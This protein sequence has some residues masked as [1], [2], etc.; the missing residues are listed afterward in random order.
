MGWTCGVKWSRGEKHQHDH[1]AAAD[2]GE[3]N[4]FTFETRARTLRDSSRSGQTPEEQDAGNPKIPAAPED[5]SSGSGEKPE[6]SS[7][8]AAPMVTKKRRFFPSAKFPFSL[9]KIPAAVAAN[10]TGSGE[11][12]LDVDCAELVGK[13]EE[14]ERCC[15]LSS[16]TVAEP[17]AR[18]IEA[19]RSFGTIEEVNSKAKREAQFEVILAATSLTMVASREKTGQ[20]VAKVAKKL[21]SEAAALVA[22]AG[23]IEPQNGRSN[24]FLFCITISG[25]LA[26]LPY[27]STQI[28]D[29]LQ[30]YISAG[31]GLVFYGRFGWS[32]S[33]LQGDAAVRPK[34]CRCSQHSELRRILFVGYSVCMLCSGIRKHHPDR[35]L[36]ADTVSRPPVCMEQVVIVVCFL[37]M[38]QTN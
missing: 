33:E 8:I 21:A 7:Q 2:D 37:R 36:C 25:T 26:L 15:S 10:P 11:K 22:K 23:T 27:I 24:D 31:F 13:L 28:P 17:T 9:N 16:F 29:S 32:N 20:E 19:V 34:G 14:L 12:P 35:Y 30:R 5:D 6:P 1:S 4:A 18:L 38:C 3:Q